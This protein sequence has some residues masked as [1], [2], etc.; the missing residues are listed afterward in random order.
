VDYYIGIDA[1]LLKGIKCQL[2]IGSPI[3]L[4]NES[5]IIMGLIQKKLET[6]Q[7]MPQVAKTEAI[8]EFLRND[9]NKFIENV[10]LI[11]R[12]EK[13]I[14][15][16]PAEVLYNIFTYLDLKSLYNC[17]Q[18]CQ[19]FHQIAKDPLLYVE[20][21]LKFYWCQAD[22][23]LIRSLH[24]RCQLIKKLDLSSCGYFKS[25][26]PEDFITFLRLNG[27]TLTHLRLNSSQFMNSYCLQTIGF[28]CENLVEL[29]MRNYGSITTDREFMTLA[30]L[31]KLETLDLTRSGID[32]FALLSILK[33]NTNL[34]HLHLA[35]NHQLNTDQICLQISVHNKKLKTIDLWKCHNLTT[36][37]L[38][39]LSNCEKLEIVDLGWNLREESNITDTFKSLIQNCQNLKKMI[40]AA[41]RGIAERD[42][43]NVAVYCKNLEHLDLMGIV[44]MTVKK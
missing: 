14:D 24:Q 25:I 15:D 36:V 28:K 20:V 13:I 22:S 16:I 7:F 35:F 5:K 12:K 40:L 26:L 4:Q 29:S 43:E 37:G 41:V 30:L 21:N 9:L 34:Q 42:L 27:K 23:I 38:R 18:V 10:G 2:P 31:A 1:V 32:T 19:K 17:S 3:K 33:N 8:E 44:G 39:A 6:V 11:E